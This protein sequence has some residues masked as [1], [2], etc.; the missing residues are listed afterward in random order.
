MMWKSSSCEL[1]REVVRSFPFQ[2]LNAAGLC[3]TLVADIAC[4]GNA[5][6][7]QNGLAITKLRVA[8]MVFPANVTIECS[9]SESAGRAVGI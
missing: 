1:S 4:L 9:Y 8:S 2:E 3:R 6:L 5:S 7:G